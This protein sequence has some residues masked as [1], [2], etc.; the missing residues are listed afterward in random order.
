M[1]SDLHIPDGEA[2]ETALARTTHLGIGA[3][4]DDL[5]F[6][7]LHGILACYHSREKW[8]GGIICTNGAGSSRKGPYADVTGD[9]LV[10]IRQSEQKLA[11][12]V[13]RYSFVAQ[14]GHSSKDIIPPLQSALVGELVELLSRTQPDVIYTHNPA[15][16]HETHVRVLVAVLQA[17]KELPAGRRPKQLLGCEMW[18]GLDWL[19]DTDKVL[20]DVGGQ[21]HLAAALSGVFDSQI[22]GG[23][24]YDL[25]VAGRWRANATLFEP[26]A[27]D[28][29]SEAALALDLTPLIG[30]DPADLEEFTLG[31]VN[32]L[33]EDIRQKI[34]AALSL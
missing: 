29:V 20:L 14:L 23:K 24:R 27:G 5:E 3:H 16:K 4:Q 17:L 6:M 33:R 18:R 22:G 32:R 7:A 12:S 15:D 19:P 13:G 26:R 11:A 34:S 9:E 2:E 25:A 28:A 21:P 8:F 31:Y 10:K 30:R 1:A